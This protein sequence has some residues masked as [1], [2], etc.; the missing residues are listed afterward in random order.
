MLVEERA[1]LSLSVTRSIQHTVPS[2]TDSECQRTSQRIP[3]ILNR[4]YQSS[5]VD[6]S[7]FTRTIPSDADVSTLECGLCQRNTASRG[8]K[9][10]KS[11]DQDIKM[12]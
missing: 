7:I 6:L 10:S 12:K 1:R 3:P 9:T 4:E 8:T 2:A 5:D 11:N